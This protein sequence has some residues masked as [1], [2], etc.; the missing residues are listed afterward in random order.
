MASTDWEECV[1]EDGES[2]RELDVLPTPQFPTT[3]DDGTIPATDAFDASDPGKIIEV[4]VCFVAGED[5]LGN[6]QFIGAANVDGPAV[7][8]VVV[9]PEVQQEWEISELG[10]QIF[11]KVSL[12][13]DEQEL[14]RRFKEND[15]KSNDRAVVLRLDFTSTS[16]RD[17]KVDRPYPVFVEVPIQHSGSTQTNWA[18]FFIFTL[19]SFLLPLLLLYAYNFF[20]GS[21]FTKT[22]PLQRA[23]VDVVVRNGQLFPAQGRNSIVNSED[24]GPHAGVRSRSR[25]FQVTGE[26]GQ[27]AELAGRMPKLPHNEPWAEGRFQDG[28]PRYVLSEQ[29]TSKDLTGGRLTPSAAPAWLLGISVVDGETERLSEDWHGRLLVV[30]PSEPGK[31]AEASFEELLPQINKALDEH[32]EAMNEGQN[33]TNVATEESALDESSGVDPISPPETQL[34][35]MPA[36]EFPKP[37]NF[38]EIP[39]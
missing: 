4:E 32:N 13:A 11:I 22:G 18:L 7:S 2:L 15:E 10:E 19:G 17:E 37:N 36:D 25:K 29:G 31:H 33:S 24:F 26:V 21:R 30:L 35:E 3:C 34:P 39:D 12:R 6:V 28:I 20:W 5:G 16:E 14:M 9:R 23:D 27:V 38:P 8:V 1:G